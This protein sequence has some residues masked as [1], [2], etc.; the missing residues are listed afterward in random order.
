VYIK[1]T[2]APISD[3]TIDVE[4]EISRLP[5]TKSISTPIVKRLDNVSFMKKKSSNSFKENAAKRIIPQTLVP[6]LPHLYSP[7][8]PQLR[9]VHIPEELSVADVGIGVNPQW[10]AKARNDLRSKI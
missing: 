10:A 2:T 1:K 9:V 5:T 8:G 3:D 4:F 7:N 6:I